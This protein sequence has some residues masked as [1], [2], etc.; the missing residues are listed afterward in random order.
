MRTVAFWLMGSFSGANWPNLEVAVPI[1]LL[2]TL[3]FMS[4]YR[5]LNL[6]LLGDEVSITLGTNLHLYRQ[7]YLLITSIIIGF[8]VYNSGIIGFVGLIVPHI[9]RMIF[10]TDH[11]KILLISSLIGA[12]LLIWSDVISRLIIPGSEI[13][14]GIV[15]SLIGAPSF[16]Y[17]IISKTYGFGGKN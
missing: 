11:K 3:F 8:L 4:Q 14:V 6:M 16:V 13:P 7:I 1:V 10:G 9:A 15:I 2:S 12:I 5:N 17:L